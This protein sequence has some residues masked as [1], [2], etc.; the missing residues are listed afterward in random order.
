MTWDGLWFGWYLLTP[1]AM[2]TGWFVWAAWRIERRWDQR[3]DDAKTADLAASPPR[4]SLPTIGRR[5]D[6]GAVWH[7][8]AHLG[9]A[10]CPA[11]K[12]NL[13]RGLLRPHRPSHLGRW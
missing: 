13:R 10:E 3:D 5:P 6:D 7:V 9:A 1:L 8:G 4:T 12:R 11:C 2:W